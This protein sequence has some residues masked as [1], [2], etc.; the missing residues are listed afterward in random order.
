[1]NEILLDARGLTC[2]LP[3]LKANRILRGMP[4][5]GRLRVM[6]TDRAS[7]ADFQAFCRETGHALIAFGE[8]GG[9]LSFVIRRK[10]DTVNK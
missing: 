8:E 6:A 10:Q 3:V 2:P 9:T 4:G 7:V 5:G 1:M